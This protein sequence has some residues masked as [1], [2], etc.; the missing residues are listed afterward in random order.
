MSI[1]TPM[2]LGEYTE[3]MLSEVN[4]RL[5]LKRHATHEEVANLYVYLAS[6]NAQYITGQVI[7]IDGG[8]TA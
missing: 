7:S 4:Q 5:P 6:K 1:L 8:E 3:E 2:Q